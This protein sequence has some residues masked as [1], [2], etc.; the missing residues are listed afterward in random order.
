L[1]ESDEDNYRYADGWGVSFH[2]H[3]WVKC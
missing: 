3:A 1:V 2:E